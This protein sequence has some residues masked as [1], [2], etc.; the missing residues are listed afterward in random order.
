M[1][2]QEMKKVLPWGSSL[3]KKMKMFFQKIEV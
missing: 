1:F 2:N 3:A